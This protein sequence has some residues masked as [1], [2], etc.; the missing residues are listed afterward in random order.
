MHVQ[1]V[2]RP[3]QPRSNARFQL[4]AGDS[5]VHRRSFIETRAE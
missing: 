1:P 5:L 2:E 4:V 3:P